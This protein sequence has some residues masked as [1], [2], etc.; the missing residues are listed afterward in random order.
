MRL[1]FIGTSHGVP[2]PHRRCSSLILETGGS[3][4]LIDMGTQVIE[5]LRRR[6]IDVGKV[7]L[8]IC[9]HPHGDH[10]DGLIS[11]ADLLNWYFKSAETQILLPDEALIPPLTAWLTAVNNGKEPRKDLKISA[12]GE[13]V[14]FEDEK[15]RLTAIKTKHC[16]NSYAF[17]IEAEGKKL[18]IT[19]DLCRP[20]V[21]FPSIAFETEI[22]LLVC[23]CAH[24]SPDEC[25]EVFDKTKAKRILHT[26]V[27]DGRWAAALLAQLKAEHPYEY[28]VA[29][30]GMEIEL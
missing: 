29:F 4:Y 22:D 1:V 14:A 3:F 23:E 24:F 17:L 13:G 2:E 20:S 7:R 11:F 25:V 10:T 28:G 30:D 18:L 21:D 6:G 5:D 15:L 27:N 9:T 19:G 12:F 26:H 8:A 16:E